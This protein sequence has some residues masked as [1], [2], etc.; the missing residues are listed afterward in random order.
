V[1]CRSSAC[2]FSAATVSTNQ[3][4]SVAAQQGDAANHQPEGH[5]ASG[6]SDRVVIAVTNGGHRGDR[7]PHRVVEVADVGI[8]A[9]PLGIEY[10]QG[11]AEGQ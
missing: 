2:S 4:A 9:R 3:D 1:I 10:G 11:G 5:Q 8:R 6:G 7:P